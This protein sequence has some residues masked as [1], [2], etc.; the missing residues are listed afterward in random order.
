MGASTDVA[1]AQGFAKASV[2]VASVDA[3]VEDSV[4]VASVEAFMEA[5]V[6]VNSVE[7]SVEVASVEASTAWKRGS[8]R[9]SLHIFMEA[10]I[11]STEGST[12]PWKLP[13][14]PLKIPWKRL[15]LPWK[16]WNCPCLPWKLPWKLSRASTKN[17]EN[18]G[19]PVRGT[20]TL[21]ASTECTEQH[22]E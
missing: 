7:A 11:A 4:E 16:S 1:S 3:S 5:S 2:D 6:E 17:S 13:V 20:G 12:L 14:L 8:V 19:N 22:D 10:S 9:G 18:T 21:H 15:K